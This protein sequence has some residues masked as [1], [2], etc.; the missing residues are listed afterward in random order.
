VEEE[1]EEDDESN[2]EVNAAA[3][4]DAVDEMDRA[5]VATAGLDSSA[6]GSFRSVLASLGTGD[7]MRESEVSCDEDEA[8]ADDGAGAGAGTAAGDGE[9]GTGTTVA[10]AVAAIVCGGA[11]TGASAGDG[12]DSDAGG[13]NEKGGAEFATVPV[14]DARSGTGEKSR[15]SGRAA[16]GPALGDGNEEG[17]KE[18]EDGDGCCGCWREVMDW[19]CLMAFSMSKEGIGAADGLVA[20]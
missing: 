18:K 15:R 4:D 8:D 6:A 1:E 17:E 9:R 2:E 14:D 3:E 7:G 13:A 19:S 20:E 5:P 11:H 10:A 16:F 12:S